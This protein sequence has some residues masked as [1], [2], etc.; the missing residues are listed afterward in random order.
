MLVARLELPPGGAAR[1]DLV[2]RMDDGEE[3]RLSDLPLEPGASELI[4]ATPIDVIRSLPATSSS[5]AWSRSAPRASGPWGST[6]SAT[7]RGRAP[8]V[9]VQDV[10]A[11]EERRQAASPSRRDAGRA[12]RSG[13]EA[14]P[15][16][17]RGTRGRSAS[18][19]RRA[20]APAPRHGSNGRSGDR[21]AASRRRPRRR[22]EGT[23]PAGARCG[24][25]GGSTKSP[26]PA[27]VAREEL[28][29]GQRGV[30]EEPLPALDPGRPQPL[31]HLGRLDV[32]GDHAEVEALCQVR[33]RQHDLVGLG[34]VGDAAGQGA[35]DLEDRDDA[36]HREVGDGA[37]GRVA[38]AEV[39]HREGHPVVAGGSRGS[40]S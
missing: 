19:S 12:P 30:E 11:L 28:A 4:L 14:P 20:P 35:V 38:G 22:G 29:G 18:A 26:A 25:G 8:G 23:A 36:A 37:Q 21:R 9:P 15:G 31:E 6:R 1:V 34:G 2:S 24:R 40:I 16:R 3:E 7:H 33:H 13:R 17:R 39:V 32:R 5:S 27:G 10:G